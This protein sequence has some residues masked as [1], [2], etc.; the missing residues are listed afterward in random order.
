MKTKT[1]KRT[2]NEIIVHCTATRE[3][4][5]ITVEQIDKWHR[6]R[7]W[8][9][10]GYHFVVYLDGSVHVGRDV[11]EVGAHCLNHNK[12]SIGVC[13]VGGCAKDG[14]TPKDTRTDAQKKALLTLI[15]Q[16]KQDYPQ[17]TVYGHR[18]FV[19]KACP[20]FDAYKEYNKQ[21]QEKHGKEEEVQRVWRKDTGV[22]DR[23]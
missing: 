11:D 12:H 23:C 8:K 6:Q 2:I 14:K 18:E 5:D 7:G 10:I 4:K 1:T 22:H 9:C 16:L 19:N 13:Y 17:A 21:K 15:N 3:G 20:C